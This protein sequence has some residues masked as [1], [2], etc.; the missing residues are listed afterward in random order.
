VEV[1]DDVRLAT[2]VGAVVEDGVTKEND[3]GM[4]NGRT[5]GGNRPAL[6]A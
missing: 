6:A 2:G 3:V 4:K 5:G 1:S